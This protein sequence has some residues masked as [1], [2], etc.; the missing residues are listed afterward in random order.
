[1]FFF[2][3]STG[4]MQNHLEQTQYGSSGSVVLQL[5]LVAS[6]SDSLL[7]LMSILAQYLLTKYGLREIMIASAFL[8]TA[9]LEIA[10]FS[11]EVWHLILSVGVVFGTGA[12][13]FFYAS[14][15]I[16]PQ[17]FGKK[18]GVAQGIVSSGACMGGL[19]LPFIMTSLNSQ[20]G[21]HW[22]FRVLGLMSLVIFISASFSFKQK[23]TTKKKEPFKKIVNF[24]V[25][26]NKNLLIWCLADNVI[27]AGYYV[28]YFF[29][30]LH[31]TSLGLSETKT[32]LLISLSSTFNACGRIIAGYLGDKIGYINI[33]IVCSMI[34]SLSA[35]VIWTH[36]YNFGTL[37]TFACI[38]GMNAGVFSALSPSITHIVEKDNFESGYTMFLILTAISFYGLNVAASLESSI[39]LPDFLVCKIFT[40][41]TYLIGILTLIVLKMR[42]SNN[43]IFSRL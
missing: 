43:N 4:I 3:L 5:S 39:H 2:T 24:S 31:A 28:P 11:T 30:P 37:L 38:Y 17:W 18:Q 42:L 25:L 12:S 14:T 10:S 29:L 16:I 7:N 1:F 19:L 26:K 8:C 40:G 13:V 21:A 6:I 33:T 15:S 41:S 27:E 32:S 23:Q 22:C 35:F 36:A 9:G 20:Y 34:A